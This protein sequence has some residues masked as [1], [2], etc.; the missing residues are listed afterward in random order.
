MAE[1]TLSNQPNSGTVGGDEPLSFDEGVQTLETLVDPD[2]QDTPKAVED[3]KNEAEDGVEEQPDEEQDSETEDTTDD[4]DEEEDEDSTKESE[5]TEEEDEDVIAYAD[6]VVVELEGEQTTLG[7]I[8]ETRL[9]ERVKSFQADYTKKTQEVAEERRTIDSQT[10]K[11]VNIA[12]QTK[13][14]RDTFLAFQR[15]FAPDPPDVSMVETDPA[16][17]QRHKAYYDEWVNG[18]NTFA[19][20][21]QRYNLQQQQE[22]MQQQEMYLEDQKQLMVESLPELGTEEGFSKF[23]E[24]LGEHFIPHYGYTVEELNQI[25]DHRFARLAK[26][27]MSYRQLKGTAPETK[28]KLEGKPKIIK[29]GARK[30]SSKKVSASKARQDRLAKTGELDA[31][32]DALMDFD[33]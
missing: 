29:P 6:D 3:T 17:Y 7:E 8:V 30:V 5:E 32:I 33:L 20:E 26:D 13:Q 2:L 24:D 15:Q 28:K 9:Q 16:G 1:E 4:T 10:E 31:A 21:S 12:E 25:T 18:Y 22:M 23:K 14:Q 19:Q 11:L 27:A